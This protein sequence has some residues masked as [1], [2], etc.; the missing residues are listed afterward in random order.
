FCSVWFGCLLIVDYRWERW[1]F[2]VPNR[3]RARIFRVV[4]RFAFP[5]GLNESPKD[6]PLVRVASDVMHENFRAH[7]GAKRV[8]V[9][10]CHEV[11]QRIDKF[12]TL[13]KGCLFERPF[14]GAKFDCVAMI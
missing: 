9:A 13:E 10:R 1:I 6:W 2:V 5:S 4:W 11:N 8:F 3:P 14:K 12:Q 7:F